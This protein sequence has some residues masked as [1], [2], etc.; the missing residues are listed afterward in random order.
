VYLVFHDVK[1]SKIDVHVY[2]TLSKAFEKS[3]KMASICAPD[4]R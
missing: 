3:R 4:L 1:A 2:W